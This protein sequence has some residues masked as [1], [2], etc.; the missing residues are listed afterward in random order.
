MNLQMKFPATPEVTG[1]VCETCYWTKDRLTANRNIN[2]S[3]WT[4]HNQ[5]HMTDLL[6]IT[7]RVI[8][9]QLN[10]SRSFISRNLNKMIFIMKF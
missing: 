2:T 4:G 6:N 1:V 7:F 10:L 8:T 9:R 3:T 5:V